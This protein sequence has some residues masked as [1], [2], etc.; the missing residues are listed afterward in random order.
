MAPIITKNPVTTEGLKEKPLPKLIEKIL[1]EIRQEEEKI[2]KE[3]ESTQTVNQVSY[4]KSLVSVEDDDLLP[5]PPSLPPLPKND[6]IKERLSLEE[7]YP[8]RTIDPNDIVNTEYRERTIL[9][10]IPGYTVKMLQDCGGFKVCQ[11]YINTIQHL[12]QN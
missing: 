1:K 11:V 3:E 6:K 5:P 10:N 8:N 12:H 2:R 4:S 7:D 9:M